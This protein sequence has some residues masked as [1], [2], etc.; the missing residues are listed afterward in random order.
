MPSLRG[1]GPI[2]D[3]RPYFRRFRAF[4]HHFTGH[5][6]YVDRNISIKVDHTHRVCRNALNI[7][8]SLKRP[9]EDRFLILLSA[10]F[11]DTG[12]FPQIFR[13]KT[14]NDLKSEDHARLGVREIKARN[15]LEGLEERDRHAILSTV[16]L[17]NRLHL[18]ASLSP[19][20]RSLCNVIRDADKLDILSVLNHYYRSSENGR[21][22]ALDLELPPG[23]AIS[24]KALADVLSARPVN[25]ANV[26][27]IHDF[28]L[29][30]ASWVFDLHFEYSMQHLRDTGQITW[31]L[32]QLPGGSQQTDARAKI[33]HHM[34]GFR[35]D[36]AEWK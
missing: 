2:T 31:L 33:N 26:H 20:N 21:N 25:I 29:L 17:H 19:R 4:V 22:P 9:R 32:D 30:Q 28:R 1:D 10:L 34:R 8:R 16:M 5:S 36:Q 3:I 7:A 15:L 23:N 35:P 24:P 18:P 11:H 13:Y 27:S 14:F 12:R 6:P